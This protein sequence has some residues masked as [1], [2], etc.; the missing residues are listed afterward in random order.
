MSEPPAFERI[1]ASY[2]GAL[3]QLDAYL[4]GG[5]GVESDQVAAARGRLD[6]VI[7][8]LLFMAG[9]R[10]SEVSALRCRGRRSVRTECYSALA[11]PRTQR[12][13]ASIPEGHGRAPITS[14]LPSGKVA[15]N[16]C[17]SPFRP[18]GLKTTSGGHRS[19]KTSIG[20]NLA[21]KRP[22]RDR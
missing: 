21:A 16:S 13:S 8:G 2:A 15:R 9:M 12:P 17:S 6:A 7:A 14:E 20:M 18:A 4:A 1:L 19:L 11:K 10:R 22:K 5:R 3:G